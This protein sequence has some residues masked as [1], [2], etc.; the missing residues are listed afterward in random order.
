[1]VKISKNLKLWDKLAPEA[2]KSGCSRWIMKQ[3]CKDVGLNWQKNG[4]PYRKGK[5]FGLCHLIWEVERIGGSTTPILRIRT[6]GFDQAIK[7]AEMLK[8]RPIRPDIKK[9]MKE[10]SCLHCNKKGCIP[11]HKNDA[12]NDPRVH[13]KSTQK[14]SDFQ[15]LCNGCNIIK[16]RTFVKTE[17]EGKRQPAPFA[18]TSLGF[19]KFIEGD[20]T[21][22]PNDIDGMVGTYWYDIEAYK[23]H[24]KTLITLS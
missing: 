11:D 9:A 18:Y 6:T 23:T 10:K 12:Y 13:N 15:A 8:N 14:I 7:R 3:E 17:K 16:A 4:G 20:E 21:F 2:K 19:P 24:C 5:M 22:N 1:M